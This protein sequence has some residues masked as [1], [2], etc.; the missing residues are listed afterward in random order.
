MLLRYPGVLGVCDYREINWIRTFSNILQPC[1][2]L[3][4]RLSTRTEKWIA[5]G[6]FAAFSVR[7]TTLHNTY[8]L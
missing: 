7:L 8:R 2:Q 6:R 3:G 1:K 5:A 4:H